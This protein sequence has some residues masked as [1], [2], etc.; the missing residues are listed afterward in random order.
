MTF[1]QIAGCYVH[2]PFCDRIC[3]YC[4]FAVVRYDRRR[5]IRYIAALEQEIAGA[6]APRWPV[7]TIFFGGGTPSALEADQIARVLQSIFARFD[8]VPGDVECSLEANPSRNAH[9]LAGWR[10]AGVTRLSVGVQSFDDGEL[11]RLGRDHSAEQAISFVRAA[12]GIGYASVS[13]DLIAGTP[14]QTTDSFERSV[15]SAVEL[16]VDHM[17]VYGLTVE[18]GTP[19]AAWQQREPSAFPDD[20]TVGEMLLLAHDVLS[21]AG[22]GHYELS[23]FAKP[24]HECNHNIGYWR[25]RDC[26]AFGMSAAG[27]EDGLRYRNAR[28]FEA[29]CTALES[30]ASAR[31]EFERLDASSRVGEAAMLALR[32]ADGIDN[33]DF[34]RRFSIDAVAVFAAARKK[35][36]AAGLL[37]T[38]ERGARLTGRGRLLANDVCAEF[39]TPSLETPAAAVGRKGA[40]VL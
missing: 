4:D 11:H 28:E 33:D 23:N 25:Q 6:E 8:V 18:A 35:C 36:S 37:E 9:D 31:A 20:D 16:G 38:D 15:R 7:R 32:T 26:I 10:A 13:V 30:G 1:D 22:F 19:Y 2:L 3:P 27:Y 5:A 14:G 34:R 24:G 21:E 17:S 29:Y 12:R 40:I 39:L